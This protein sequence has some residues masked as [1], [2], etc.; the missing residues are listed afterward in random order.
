M[1]KNPTQRQLGYVS[2]LWLLGPLGLVIGQPAL[3][4]FFFFGLLGL[5]ALFPT[6]KNNS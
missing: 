3:Y 2:F 5:F 1:F 4:G 6:K